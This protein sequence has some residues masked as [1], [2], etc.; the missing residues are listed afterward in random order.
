[1]SA[2]KQPIDNLY[3]FGAR[4]LALTLLVVFTSTATSSARQLDSVRPESSVV[5]QDP[6]MKRPI[7]VAH[8]GASADA[9]EN[10]LA[11]FRLGWEQ[12]A[13]AIEGDFFLTSDEQIVAMHDS[14]TERTTG[15]TWDVRQKNLAELRTLDVGRWKHANFSGERI[16]TLSEVVQTIP[17]GK[18]LFLEIKDSARLVP[19]LK[20]LRSTDS[21]LAA[22]HNEHLVIIAFDAEVIAAVKREL[23]DVAAFW[24]T[25]FKPDEQTG[26]IRPS[27]AE[28]LSTLQRT[29]ADGLD[30]KAA[31]HIDQHFVDQIRANGYQFHVWTVDDPVIANRFA[32]F[33]VDSIT[34]NVP[35]KIRQQLVLHFARPSR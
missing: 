27:L 21:T 14:S 35:A 5:D 3:G 4:L 17:P 20:R 6:A 19:V 7:I 1:V 28:I 12:E 13:D 29:G 23:P 26:E 15:T 9:P 25:G 32:D 30:C 24:L 18:K 22:L 2:E 16:P 31:D 33:G 34:T 11:A 8:R 10:T